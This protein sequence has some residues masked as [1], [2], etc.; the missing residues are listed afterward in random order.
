MTATEQEINN[1]NNAALDNRN[2]FALAYLCLARDAKFLKAPEVERLKLIKSVLSFG[3]SVARGIVNEFGTNE[4]RE[5]TQKLGLKVVGEDSGS[6]GSLL[7]RS[8]YRPKRKE[9]VIYRDSLNKLMK[10]VAAD[11]LSDRLMK[12]LIAH[13]LFHFF[14]H[15]SYGSIPSR[16]N[17]SR[18]EMGPVSLK[19][20]V[21]AVKEVAAHAFAETLLGIKQTPLV[22]DYLTYMFYSGSSE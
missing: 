21:P 8:E 18:W 3:D 16:F 19:A 17:V 11:D 2:R 6:L 7:K 22:F 4:P 12:L 15:T 10:E 1:Q 5:I 14:E 9:I 13:E 20:E